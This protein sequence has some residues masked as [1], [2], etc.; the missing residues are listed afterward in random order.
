MLSMCSGSLI[1]SWLLVIIVL[2]TAELMPITDAKPLV[3]ATQ[4]LKSNGK[5]Y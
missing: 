2:L 4:C 5:N 1:R 3:L